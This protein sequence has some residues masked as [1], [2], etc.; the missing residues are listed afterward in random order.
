MTNLT[1]SN[2]HITEIKV[3]YAE[4]DAMGFVYYANYFTYFEVCRIE[5]L[6]ALGHPYHDMEKKNVFI[7][8]IS[9]KADYLKPARFGDVLKIRT[10]W[11][12]LGQ[13]RIQ[14]SYEVFVQDYLI[15][16]GETRHPFMNSDGKPIRPPKDIIHLFPQLE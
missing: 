16:T 6:G 5:A 7:P 12:R 11:H 13:A 10:L 14:F 8:V 9:A 2:S 3:R 15:A 4:T 1:G